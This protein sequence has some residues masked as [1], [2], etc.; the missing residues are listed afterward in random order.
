MKIQLDVKFERWLI[1]KLPSFVRADRPHHH[2][3]RRTIFMVEPDPTCD[4]LRKTYKLKI[5]F[6]AR[7]LT[8]KI[9]CLLFLRSIIPA[10]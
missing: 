4:K 1:Y 7:V 2:A 5:K 9:R 8:H 6:N 10:Y 3:N